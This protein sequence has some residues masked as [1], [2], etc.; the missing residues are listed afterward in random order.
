MK[1]R[2][3]YKLIFEQTLYG[4]VYHGGNW[5]GKTPIKMS[6]GSLGT[7]AYFTPNINLAKQY[8]VQNE[9][10]VTE[11]L[12]KVSNPLTIKTYKDKHV[13]PCV[14]ALIILGMREEK[15]INLVE[16]TEEQKGYMGKEISSR[17]FEK[18]YDCIFQYFDDELR[19]IVVWDS[20]RVV[21]NN[22][23]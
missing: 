11:V 1:F 16:K 9:G 10:T 3:F 14:Q 23:K 4:P 20:S 7:G 5:N 2:D 13:H 18:G 12:L 15:A 6:K 22:N 19:E 21:F 8:A 17:A